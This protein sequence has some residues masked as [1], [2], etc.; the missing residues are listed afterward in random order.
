M[1]NWRIS[2]AIMT[3]F[4]AMATYVQHNDDHPFFWM[5]VY[6]LPCSIT[7]SMMIDLKLCH[8]IHMQRFLLLLLNMYLFFSIYLFI[9]AIKVVIENNHYNLLEFQ[10]CK[11]LFGILIIECWLMICIYV[12]NIR[13]PLEAWMT[14]VSKLV[15]F[16]LSISP[17]LLWI[18]HGCFRIFISNS[19]NT[20]IKTIIIGSNNFSNLTAI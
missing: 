16:L 5:L 14:S 2:N 10:E 13:T 19:N 11:E 20:D 15:I 17:I 4:F 8:T 12:I 1:T 7:F 18:Y 3:A 6:A 9:R